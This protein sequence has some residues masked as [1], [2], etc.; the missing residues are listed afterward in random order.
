MLNELMKRAAALR[1]FKLLVGSAGLDFTKGLD[2]LDKDVAE[3]SFQQCV[4]FSE[5]GQLKG[6]QPHFQPT[7]AKS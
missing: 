5:Q 7:G 2:S 1:G 3:T 6:W 4:A